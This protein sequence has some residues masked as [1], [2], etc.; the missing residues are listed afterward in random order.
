MKGKYM[1]KANR[2]SKPRVANPVAKHMRTFNKCAV[3]TDR[4][5]SLKK[6]YNKHKGN[7]YGEGSYTNACL[8]WL[9]RVFV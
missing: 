8:A 9:H 3:Q 7:Q 2:G 1:A 5:K 6:G 4:K